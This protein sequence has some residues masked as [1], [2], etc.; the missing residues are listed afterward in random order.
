MSHLGYDISQ[1]DGQ[2]WVGMSQQLANTLEIFQGSPGEA[3][4]SP[5]PSSL[6]TGVPDPIW[7]WDYLWGGASQ[8]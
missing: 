4:S 7:K 3:S 8:L 2:N 5:L 6:L 1:P